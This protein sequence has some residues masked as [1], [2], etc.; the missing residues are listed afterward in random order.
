[1]D[2]FYRVKA[3]PRPSE[4]GYFADT[5]R[6]LEKSVVGGVTLNHL[7]WAS[8]LGVPCGLM[9]LQG[10]DDAGRLIRSVMEQNGMTREFIQ[11]SEHYASSQSLVFLEPDGER[12]IMMAPA[13]TAEITA[14][15]VDQYF[16]N[17]VADSCLL[18]TEIS[19]LPLSAVKRLLMLAKQHN[20]LSVLDVDVTPTVSSTTAN[21]G[22]IEELLSCVELA[23]VVKPGYEAA[24]EL[25][26]LRGSTTPDCVEQLAADLRR[27][28][29]STIVAM[30]DG[31]RGCTF[32]SNEGTIHIDVFNTNKV[33]DTTGAGDA[34]LGGMIAGIYH[35][36]IHTDLTYMSYLGKL[37]SATGAA[38][39]QVMGA[40]PD[41]QKSLGVVDAFL[42]EVDVNALVAGQRRNLAKSGL[43]AVY[44]EK[45]AHQQKQFSGLVSTYTKSMEQDCK[46]LTFN[47]S[48]INAAAVENFVETL[49]SHENNSELNGRGRLFVTAIGKS[50]MVGQRLAASLSSIGCSAEYVHAS[51]WVHGDLGKTSAGDVVIALSHSG[52][53]A[54][55]IEAIPHLQRRNVTVCA[56]T[57]SD[58][59]PLAQFA[60]ACI[61]YDMH[62]DAPDLLG[63]VPSRSLIVQEAVC[64]GVVSCVAD[65][66]QVTLRDFIFSHPG[67]SIG[68]SWHTV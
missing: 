39:I 4:K 31:N 59:C 25:L 8:L 1:V 47:A 36:G 57:S 48:H 35:W 24:C 18:T 52:K 56:I 27:E 63:K 23:D 9:T 3:M 51:E 32:A 40:L 43:D 45:Q 68:A 49:L 61:A 22:S 58:T 41:R 19:Q 42:P 37:A 67:G 54:E 38:C 16:A 11:V 13:S 62:K 60:D 64:N 65:R 44:E 6:T 20:V 55:L 28:Y 7:A 2:H 30:T 10:D 34:F 53:T 17:A 14:E 29:N 15:T 33:V 21:L 12:A 66:K 50:G 5:R 26:E 46:A